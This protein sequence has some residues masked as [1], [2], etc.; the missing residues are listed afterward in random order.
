MMHCGVGAAKSTSDALRVAWAIC[1][2]LDFDLD[3]GYAIR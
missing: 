1:I 2:T 3:L